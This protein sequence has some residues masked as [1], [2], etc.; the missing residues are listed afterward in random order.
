MSATS[1][2]LAAQAEQLQRTIS[3]FRIDATHGARPASVDATVDHAV[4]SSRTR[5][6]RC[7]AREH[8]P[9]CRGRPH[10]Q[11]AGRRPPA[12]GG[13]A[14]D[15][16]APT[17]TPRTPS[18]I[19]PDRRHRRAALRPP[20]PCRCQWIEVHGRYS[21]V[22]DLGIDRERF[23]LRRSSASARFSTCGRSRGCR[24]RRPIVLGLID[25][26]GVGL[27]VVD[28]RTKFGFPPVEATNR[29]RIILV[30]AMFDGNDSGVGLVADCVFAVSDLSGERTRASAV[31]R[32]ALARRLRRRGRTRGRGFR[33]R[34]RSRSVASRRS[35]LAAAQVR[36]RRHVVVR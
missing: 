16:C 11:G 24:T 18:S 27:P 22:S 12:A 14:L 21:S 34:A 25:V 32:R 15:L 6:R 7:G 26:R 20:T 1:E 10:R 29:T 4:R 13:F 19:G 33:H 36:P 30:D 17:K 31:D 8:K 3:Y 9:H 28:L 5:P 2:E 35:E 23:A